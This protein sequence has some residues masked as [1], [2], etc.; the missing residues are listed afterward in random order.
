M[1]KSTEQPLL[2]HYTSFEVLISI[3]KKESVPVMRA[4]HID[5]LNDKSELKYGLSRIIDSL[6]DDND[7]E[8]I[9]KCLK[10]RELLVAIGETLGLHFSAVDTRDFLALKEDVKNIYE[11]VVI[12]QLISTTP[13]FYTFSLSTAPDSLYQWLAYSSQQ[14][15]IALVFHNFTSLVDIV[16]DSKYRHQLINTVSK[17]DYLKI[18]DN[19][20]IKLSNVSGSKLDYLASN[21]ILIKHPAYEQE[22]EYRLMVNLSNEEK[23]SI[24]IHYD[25]SKPYI[26]LPFDPILLKEI[27]ISPRGEK[28]QS[29]KLVQHFL[30]NTPC[31][32]H[33][34]I[35]VSDIPY[36]G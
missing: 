18:G 27:Y 22:K 35:F 31:L 15:G 1:S 3:F 29:E 19:V 34:K 21:A 20:D 26:E 32:S 14:G 12:E 28:D 10:E 24:P 13:D 36:R 30:S 23:G 6:N 8:T 17:V 2:W 4:T 9:G 7:N 5:F 16:D 11:R 25:A 33:V